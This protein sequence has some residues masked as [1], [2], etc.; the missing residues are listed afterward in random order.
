M[1]SRRE[2][3]NQEYKLVLEAGVDD[4]LL[5][6]LGARAFRLAAVPAGDPIPSADTEDYFVVHRIGDG[7]NSLTNHGLGSCDLYARSNSDKDSARLTVYGVNILPSGLL[8]D[9][10]LAADTEMSQ[11][12]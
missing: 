1:S 10:L 12:N 11:Y 4:Y 8:P 3:L 2:L 5:Q 7:L 6:N 9:T